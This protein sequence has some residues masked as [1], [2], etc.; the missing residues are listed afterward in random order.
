MSFRHYTDPED[1]FRLEIPADW[2]AQYGDQGG[3]RVVFLSPEVVQGFQANVNVVVN[4]VPPL[5]LDEFLILSRLQLK[6]LSGQSTL[7]VDQPAGD[8]PNGHSKAH[9]F[10]WT[11][12][13]APIPLT[14]RQLVLFS[15]PKA[16][17]LT[18]TALAHTFDQHRPTFEQIFR[19]FKCDRHD[20][21]SPHRQ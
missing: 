11:N 10:E 12:P 4:H 15:P 3:L 19:T 13:R 5:T 7:P 14:A 20:A 16:L 21:D 6:Q 8:R 1:L 9:V 18:A 17:I 2:L